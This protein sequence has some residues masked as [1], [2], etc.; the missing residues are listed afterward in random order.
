MH[1]QPATFVFYTFAARYFSSM[2]S[3]SDSWLSDRRGCHVEHLVAPH[4]AQKIMVHLIPPIPGPRWSR[5]PGRWHWSAS[6]KRCLTDVALMSLSHTPSF[7]HNFV[8]HTHTY[9]HTYMHTILLCHTPS[10][11]L[12]F[13]THNCFNFSILH[14][15]LSLSFLP[16]PRYNLW[17]SLLEEVDLWGYPVL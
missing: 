8:T 7:T 16:R 14:R 1:S 4:G 12:H 15:L 9:T 6:E 17:C 13:V 10:F 5:M 3:S 11:T 2:S